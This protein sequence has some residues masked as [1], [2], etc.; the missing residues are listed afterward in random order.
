MPPIVAR[1][2]VLP[3]DA[4]DPLLRAALEEYKNDAAVRE[5]V[6][7]VRHYSSA[8]LT[9]GNSVK[10]LVD[11]PETFAAIEAAMR[12]A[13]NNINLETFIYGADDVGHR[14]ATL[15]AQ[16]RKEGVEVRV[17]YDSLGSMDT[18]RRFFDDLRQQGIDVREFRPINPVKTPLVWN[19]H[20]RDHRKIVVVDGKVGFT[21]G[22]N[23]DSTY[24]SASTSR[25]G[26][27]RGLKDGWRD[28]HVRIEGPA[29][30]QLQRLFFES[31]QQAGGATEQKADY[32][33][34]IER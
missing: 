3:E 23:I 8:P 4:G 17:L 15:L 21:G 2:R 1:Q 20:N 14:F 32:F 31:W 34:T 30:E 6:D 22:I 18:P 12:A 19:I 10:V 29:V 26:P 33:P 16:K 27:K 28:T 25:P 11:G 5:L 9:A 24:S 7:A 13:H